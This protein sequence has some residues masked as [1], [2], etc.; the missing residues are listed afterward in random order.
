MKCLVLLKKYQW[1]KKENSERIHEITS[2]IL[3]VQTLEE[4][5]FDDT[6]QLHYLLPV[7]EKNIKNKLE[8]NKLPLN[9]SEIEEIVRV[10]NKDLLNLKEDIIKKIT[11]ILSKK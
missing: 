10:K 8:F 2:C 11:N 6:N 5:V 1:G 7:K 9:V 4:V 3:Y